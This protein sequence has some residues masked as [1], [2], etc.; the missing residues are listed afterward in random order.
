MA[1]L[2]SILATCRRMR[3]G[4]LSNDSKAQELVANPVFGKLDSRVLDVAKVVDDFEYDCTIIRAGEYFDSAFGNLCLHSALLF[5]RPL[6]GTRRCIDAVGML[7]RHF[8][9]ALFWPTSEI[10][11]DSDQ[12]GWEIDPRELLLA[13]LDG[14][15][16]TACL[17]YFNKLV[18]QLLLLLFFTFALLSLACRLVDGTRRS[19]AHGILYTFSSCVWSCV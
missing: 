10:A 12:C 19:V 2:G 1:G 8:W 14:T 4:R 9:Q 11:A 7:V 18:K 3:C 6:G 5:Q 16:A 13:L 17:K 15:C